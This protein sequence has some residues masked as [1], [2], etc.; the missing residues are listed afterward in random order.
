MF[1]FG[2]TGHNRRKDQA[3]A[4]FHNSMVSMRSGPYTL[5]TNHPRLTIVPP[6]EQLQTDAP[7]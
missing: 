2:K 7:F 6:H 3:S 1:Q 4:E 5:R